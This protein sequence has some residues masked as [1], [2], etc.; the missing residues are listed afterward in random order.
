V[1]AT[2]W[3][4]WTNAADASRFRP[5]L[6]RDEVERLE[7]AGGNRGVVVLSRT[8]DDS[9]E[10]LVLSLWDSVADANAAVACG[11]AVASPEATALLIRNDGTTYHECDVR[12]DLA[13]AA[14]L[15]DA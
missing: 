7:R 9:V 6:D 5:A 10:F 14:A 1:I 15:L 2:V 3:R 8:L 12:G 11:A 13:F 4:G